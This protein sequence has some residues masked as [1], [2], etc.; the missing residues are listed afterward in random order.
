MESD[1]QGPVNIGSEEMVTINE[2]ADIAGRIANKTF[3]RKYKLDA[4][5]G[6]RGRNSSNNLIREKLNW[7]FQM[8]LEDGL[9]RTYKWIN[10]Q[11]E[12]QKVN[13]KG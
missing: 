1:F 6:V 10:D 4:P 11:I 13:P 7:D 3:S 2:L 12:S 9:S 8:T 5:T